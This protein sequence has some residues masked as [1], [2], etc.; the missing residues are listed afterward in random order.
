MAVQRTEQ[1]GRQAGNILAH[2]KGLE[3]KKSS[4]GGRGIFL[5]FSF[6]RTYQDLA[7]SS[8]KVKADYYSQFC[9]SVIIT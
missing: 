1:M 2:S 5:D 6:Y 3:S 4:G 9:Y 8:I 7:V